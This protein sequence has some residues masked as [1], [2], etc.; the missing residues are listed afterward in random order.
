MSDQHDLDT[1]VIDW[2]SLRAIARDAAQ[3]AHAPYSGLGVGAAGQGGGSVI[4]GCNVE[5]ASYGLGL[6][7]ECGLVSAAQLAGVH[8]TAVSVQSN[9]GE[10]LMPCGRCRQV[11]YES[12][13]PDLLVDADP[14]PLRLSELL[15]RAFTSAE[16]PESKD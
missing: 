3:R 4:T 6:C 14:A 1:S 15:P 7:A 9:T 8:L 2:P 12:G 16:L 13:G 10:V 5:N 11:L